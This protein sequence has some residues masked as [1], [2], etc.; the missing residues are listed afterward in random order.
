VLPSRDRE[1]VGA[2]VIFPLILRESVPSLMQLWSRAVPCMLV[3]PEPFSIDVDS[4]YV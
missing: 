3:F 1:G 2:F 4:L